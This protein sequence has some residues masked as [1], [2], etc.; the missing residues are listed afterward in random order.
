MVRFT[1]PELTD[2]ERA[3]LVATGLFVDL[4]YF[5]KKAS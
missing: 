2:Q 5:E 3:L 1:S 4:Q